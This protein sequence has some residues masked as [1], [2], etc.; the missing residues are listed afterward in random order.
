MSKAPKTSWSKK[1]RWFMTSWGNCK[2]PGC[3][4]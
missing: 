1:N 2:K 3:S 4:S